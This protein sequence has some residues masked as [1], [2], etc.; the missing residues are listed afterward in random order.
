MSDPNLTGNTCPSCGIDLYYWQ[1]AHPNFVAA[2]SCRDKW[3][4][5]HPPLDPASHD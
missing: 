4:D 5:E 3:H 2:Q 1:H